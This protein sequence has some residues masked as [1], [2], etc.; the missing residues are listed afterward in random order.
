[1]EKTADII[2]VGIGTAGA[3]AAYYF[4]Q[5]GRLSK[6]HIICFDSDPETAETTPTLKVIQIP[7][8]PPLPVGLPADE[9]RAAME[10][11]LDANIGTPGIMVILTCLGGHTSSFYTQAALRYAGS[12]NIQAVA[13]AAMPHSFD[14]E[15]CKATASRLLAVL[16]SEHFHVLALACEELG[17]FFP[18]PGN[19]PKYAYQ[20]AIR[21]LAETANGYLHIFC[22]PRTIT[23]DAN[24]EE[25]DLT[26][27]PRG[28]FAGHEPT[29]FEGKELDPP[30]FLRKNITLPKTSN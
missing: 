6:E 23:G 7:K 1:M 14:N 27:F 5:R 10:K 3:K 8:P 26:L 29:I 9:A 2:V 21:W 4:F 25:R 16:R 15:E 12:R 13:L 24:G 17:P 28:I 19:D 11:E 22:E 20:Q 30:T 18:I